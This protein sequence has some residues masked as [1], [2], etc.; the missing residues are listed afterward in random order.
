MRRH[1]SAALSARNWLHC[2]RPGDYVVVL[3]A[4]LATA[5]SAAVLWGTDA[6]S[7][8]IV[9][10]RGQT[11]ATLPL[12]RPNH[13]EVRGPLGTTRIEVQPG[14]ARV[15]SDPGPRQYC[16]KQGWL[17]RGGAA[18]ICAPNEVTL[19]LVGRRPAY[20]SLTY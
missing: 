2:M 8:A 11:V 7:T 19:Q 14:R 9:R 18:A 17:S 4:V 3:L 13:F 20:D 12:D 1:F 16:V 15:A 10:L 5:A 6:P